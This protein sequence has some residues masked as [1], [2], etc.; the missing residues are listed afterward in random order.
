MQENKA[1]TCPYCDE[2]VDQLNRLQSDA[3]GDQWHYECVDKALA[4]F[5]QLLKISRCAQAVLDTFIGKQII[6]GA[7]HGK[8]QLQTAL[9]ELDR[10]VKEWKETD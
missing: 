4:E 1:R 7:R 2:S 3:N 10:A 5:L 6:M 8:T 9:V